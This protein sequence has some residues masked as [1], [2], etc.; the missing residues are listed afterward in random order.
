MF[1]SLGLLAALVF[2]QVY[3][4]QCNLESSLQFAD[5][6]D[7]TMTR[8]R[9]LPLSNRDAATEGEKIPLIPDKQASLAESIFLCLVVK[10]SE[11]Q[12]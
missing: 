7:G 4:S 9:G 11:G 10:P 3:V 8:I 1:L 5:E 6:S 12:G 2:V